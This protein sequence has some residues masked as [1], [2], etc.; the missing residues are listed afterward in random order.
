MTR[1]AGATGRFVDGPALR[2]VVAAVC[3]LICSSPAVL[4]GADKCEPDV[5]KVDRITKQQQVVWTQAL[6]VTS[7]G[8]EFWGSKSVRMAIG[9]GRYG[10]SSAV[11]LEIVRV[12]ASGVSASFDTSLRAV[13]GSRFFIGFRDGGEPLSFVA[14]DV[15]NE[16]KA[17]SE[18][19]DFGKGKIVTSVFLSSTLT[20]E[21]LAAM[22][23]SLT[24]REIDAIRV[25]LAG[26]LVF[27]TGLNQKAGRTVMEKFQCFFDAM[28]RT[29]ALASDPGIASAR[30][31]YLRKG[32]DSDYLLFNPDGTWSVLQDGHTARGTYEVEGEVISLISPKKKLLGRVTLLPDAIK[33]DDGIIWEKQLDSSKVDAPTADTTVTLRLGMTPEQVEA[34]QGG[35]PQKVID[36]G[37]KKTYIYPDM[38]GLSGSLCNWL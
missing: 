22:R 4:K 18:I 31:R 3:V 37:S 7:A 15:A 2:C 34:V 1:V 11:T 26:D 17:R 20:A 10:S 5:S 28:D 19:L 23:E 8:A 32:K 12:E 33:D 16:T 35:K 29:V 38:K 14:T 27:E 36:L 24:T 21:A 9:I 6:A 25:K 13:K 30:G